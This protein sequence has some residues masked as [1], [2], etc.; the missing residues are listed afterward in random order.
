MKMELTKGHD[1]MELTYDENINI[2]KNFVN[3]DTIFPLL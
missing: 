1:E 3:S 2:Q